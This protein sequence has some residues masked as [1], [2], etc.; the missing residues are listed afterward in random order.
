VSPDQQHLALLTASSRLIYIPFFERAIYRQAKLYDIAIDIQLGSSS[1]AS[2]YLAYGC[3]SNPR[4]SVVTDSGVFLIA[5]YFNSSSEREVDLTIHRV[6]PFFLDPDRL[7]L[8]TCL[9]MSDTGL[10]LTWA[11][12][13]DA[14]DTP[15]AERAMYAALLQGR[16]ASELEAQK[17]EEAILDVL[18]EPS[19]DEEEGATV[20]TRSV[21]EERQRKDVWQRRGDG[22]YAWESVTDDAKKQAWILFEWKFVRGLKAPPEIKSESHCASMLAELMTRLQPGRMVTLRS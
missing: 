11:R 20:S 19:S 8:V 22:K 14:D 13:A 1:S 10:W 5:P 16:W 21:V 7:E 3:K 15:E 9:M 12:G 17:Q 4:I 6:T 18:D 2:V